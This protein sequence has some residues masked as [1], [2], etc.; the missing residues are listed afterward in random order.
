MESNHNANITVTHTG[1]TG[2]TTVRQYAGVTVFSND[3][4]HAILAGGS[5]YL[6][7]WPVQNTIIE[8]NK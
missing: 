6:A 3:G 2:E 7:W 4:T 1:P 5:R 8:V